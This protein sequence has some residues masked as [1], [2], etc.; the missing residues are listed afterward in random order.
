M[1]VR[2]STYARPLVWRMNGL[3]HL[4]GMWSGH[5]P[6]WSDWELVLSGDRR[7]LMEVGGGDVYYILYSCVNITIATEQY[8]SIWYCGG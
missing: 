1:T 5:T 3:A 6:E 7:E 2:E 4:E 8:P